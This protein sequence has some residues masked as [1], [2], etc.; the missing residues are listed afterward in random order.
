M[1]QILD[2]YPRYGKA[3]PQALSQQAL[4]YMILNCLPQLVF[5]FRLNRIISLLE[6]C[7]GNYQIHSGIQV[8]LAYS[9]ERVINQQVC[10]RDPTANPTPPGETPGAH[11]PESG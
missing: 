2:K 11:L 10:N 6:E 7:T 5:F 9:E 3:K 4:Y 8:E 1:I